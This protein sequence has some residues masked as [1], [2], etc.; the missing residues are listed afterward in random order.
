MK[1]YDIFRP[2][3]CVMMVITGFI[4]IFACL[5]SFHR[6]FVGN[7]IFLWPYWNPHIDVYFL[8]LTL[9]LPSGIWLL[10]KK[11]VASD[12]IPAAGIVFGICTVAMGLY[13]MQ[14]WALFFQFIGDVILGIGMIVSALSFK[15]GFLHT[16]MR[17]VLIISL[18]LMMIGLKIA[19]TFALFAGNA[20]IWSI[21]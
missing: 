6:D 1:A 15:R 7:L 12:L 21:I 18:L 19:I 8:F 14:A 20:D 10:K 11:P 5:F 4:G 13:H 9:L 17:M 2:A 3:L 16:T